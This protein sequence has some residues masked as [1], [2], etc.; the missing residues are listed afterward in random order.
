VAKNK[1][2][3]L[4]MEEQKETKKTETKTGSLEDPYAQNYKKIFNICFFSVFGALVFVLLITYIIP[5]TTFLGPILDII[6]N[7]WI[8]LFIIFIFIF[9]AKHKKWALVLS[10]IFGSITVIAAL[11]PIFQALTNV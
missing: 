11:N 8:W 3:G 4:I 7:F 1:K 2:K 9:R 10:I 6:F 5:G